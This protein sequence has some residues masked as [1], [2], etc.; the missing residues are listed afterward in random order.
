M[1]FLV[2]S[3]DA[4]KLFVDDWVCFYDSQS[5]APEGIER[6]VMRPHAKVVFTKNEYSELD[7]LLD[8]K[9]HKRHVALRVSS[10][11][12]LP[13]LM[14]GTDIIIA[15]PRLISRTIMNGFPHCPLPVH[16]PDLSIYLVWHTS[17]N[18]NPLNR[19][20]RQELLQIVRQKRL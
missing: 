18:E 13:A 14:R 16:M 17:Q 2:R 5:E 4:R 6:F 19:W 1:A 11:S 12:A 10:F 9:G 3:E 15:M 7:R 20:L 8:A